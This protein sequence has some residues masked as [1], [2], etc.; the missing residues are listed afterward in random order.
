[1][2][3]TKSFVHDRPHYSVHADDADEQKLLKALCAGEAVPQYTES[4]K[5]GFVW[6][7]SKNPVI[8]TVNRQSVCD[9]KP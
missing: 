4:G 8:P 9:P 6:F 3:I 2:R 7:A 5:F 1:M